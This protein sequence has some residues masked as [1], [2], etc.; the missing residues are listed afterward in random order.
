MTTLLATTSNRYAKNIS[1]QELAI[2]IG[3]TK[4]KLSDCL[5]CFLL[6]YNF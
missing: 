4:L 2:K 6:S 3:K 5:I 1:K